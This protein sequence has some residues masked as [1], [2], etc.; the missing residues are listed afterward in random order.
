MLGVS[1]SK[2]RYRCGQAP[3]QNLADEIRVMQCVHVDQIIIVVLV[4][5]NLDFASCVSALLLL[6]AFRL[7]NLTL[8]LMTIVLSIE[9]EQYILSNQE[10]SFCAV[11]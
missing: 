5:E 3:W 4:P 11:Q 10:I 2:E 6:S 8:A 1:V 9:N 7:H